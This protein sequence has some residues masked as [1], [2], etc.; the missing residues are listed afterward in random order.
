MKANVDGVN[1]VTVTVVTVSERK[2]DGVN[3]MLL[4]LSVR[5]RFSIFIG[6]TLGTGLLCVCA[7]LCEFAMLG[8]IALFFVRERDRNHFFV[9]VPMRHRHK[10]G[11]WGILRNSY[12]EANSFFISYEL[13][14]KRPF[15]DGRRTVCRGEKKK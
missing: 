5:N 10:R 12:M 9:R 14:S 6:W 4:S 2:A 1:A 13:V 15:S 11:S 3:F 8:F 7:C